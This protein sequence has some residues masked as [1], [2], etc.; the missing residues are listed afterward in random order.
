MSNV[1][2]SSFVNSPSPPPTASLSPIMH[3]SMLSPRGKGG[4]LN[5][6]RCIMTLSNE[7][8][9]QNFFPDEAS[10]FTENFAFFYFRRCFTLICCTK[11]LILSPIFYCNIDTIRL[12]N[13]NFCF[14]KKWNV[15]QWKLQIS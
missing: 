13:L 3:L 5:I 4:E 14:F 1:D 7:H 11:Y 6:D 8:F 10:V 9:V 2:Y 12:N 15:L